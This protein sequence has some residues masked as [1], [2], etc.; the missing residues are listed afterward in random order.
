MNGREALTIVAV[1]GALGAG[2][3]ALNERAADNNARHNAAL[4]RVC[5]DTYSLENRDEV[6]QSALDCMSEGWVPGL[7]T[8]DTGNLTANTPPELFNSYI[9]E[10]KLKG[11]DF[12]EG[13]IAIYGAIGIIGGLLL[14]LKLSDME[15]EDK[16]KEDPEPE[17]ELDLDLEPKDKTIVY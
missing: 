1:S 2:V 10:Q 14:A 12:D 7:G 5:L 9:A 16:R 15:E 13:R 4:A 11:N 6:G 17:V 3:G 8:I